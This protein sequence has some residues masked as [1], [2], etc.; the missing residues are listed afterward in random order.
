M[1][2]EISRRTA[3]RG[4]GSVIALPWLEVMQPAKTLLA[5]TSVTAPWRPIYEDGSTVRFTA[6]EYG[7]DLPDGPWGPT[8]VAYLQHGSDPVVFFSTDM[9]LAPPD[10]LVEDDQRSPD[11]SEEMVWVPIVT[12]WQVL[13]DL[14]AAGSVPEGFGHLYPMV[15]NAESWIA[16][17]QP[18]GWTNSDTER[19]LLFLDEWQLA[20]AEEAG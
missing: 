19:L 12:T 11:V 3:L 8:R 2:R 16:V 13:A 15:E 6:Q 20:K 5:A 18:D 10:W 9:L 14:P 7:L 17:T 1:K 4:L